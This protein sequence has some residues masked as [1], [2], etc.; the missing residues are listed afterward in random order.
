MLWILGAIAFVVSLNSF[1]LILL[2]LRNYNNPFLQRHV[3]RILLMV[4]AYCRLKIILGITCWLT[5]KR[6][7]WV[8]YLEFISALFE[9]LAIYSFFTLLLRFV[10]PN[11]DDIKILLDS[12]PRRKL[13]Y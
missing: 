7:E 4:P 2:H 9:A 12:K 1:Y 5:F 6:F 13:V 11:E 3:V 8:V 10:G